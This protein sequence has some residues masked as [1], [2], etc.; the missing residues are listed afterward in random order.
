MGENC[1]SR[2]RA[3]I[4]IELNMTDTVKWE[5]EGIAWG[6]ERV[7]LLR[8]MLTSMSGCISRSPQARCVFSGDGESTDGS[9]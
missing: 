6:K 7:A 9:A 2:V 1:P 5:W 4:S 3:D 8:V